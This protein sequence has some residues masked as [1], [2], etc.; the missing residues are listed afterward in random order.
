MCAKRCNLLHFVPILT[1]NLSFVAYYVCVTHPL[2][3]HSNNVRTDTSYLSTEVQKAHLLQQPFPDGDSLDGE[4]AFC[5]MLLVV[6]SDDDGSLQGEGLVKRDKVGDFTM[7]GLLV[8]DTEG[9]LYGNLGNE[10]SE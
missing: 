6:T 1:F 7:A 5:Y 10:V 2:G 3:F 8:T 9:C 4:S